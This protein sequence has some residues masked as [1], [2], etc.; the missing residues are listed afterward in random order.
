MLGRVGNQHSNARHR[1]LARTS[2]T[3]CRAQG[4]LMKGQ[5]NHPGEGPGAKLMGSSSAVELAAVNRAVG[6]SIP[7]L[8]A[9]TH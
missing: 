9:S 1:A 7:P 3:A 6:G 4:V 8:P 5:T 2:V